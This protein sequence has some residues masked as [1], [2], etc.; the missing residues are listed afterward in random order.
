MVKYSRLL[1]LPV[2]LT[3]FNTDVHAT[4]LKQAS[5]DQKAE[6]IQA[7]MTRDRYLVYSLTA[8]SASFQLSQILPE[9]KKFFGSSSSETTKSPDKKSS[10][11]E[12]FKAGLR[13]MFYTQ[14]G[15]ASTI[16]LGVGIGSSLFISHLYE[17]L[18][19]PDTLRWYIHN[20]APYHAT[21]KMM[22]KKLEQ[23]QDPFIDEEQKETNKKFVILLYDRLV[24]QAQSICAY[25]TYKTGRLDDEEQ[26]LGKRAQRNM[27]AVQNNWLDRISAQL[28][29]NDCDYTT[30]NDLLC[31]YET[32]ISFHVTHFYM[33]EGEMLHDRSVVK[34]QA[35]QSLN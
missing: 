35:K 9:L 30:L 32:D 2:F 22:K 33:V 28:S 29:G 8:L 27:I 18:T 23:L 19:H 6:H 7:K 17:K 11:L 14:E 4:V 3:F 16:Q 20:H 12:G 24:Y 34:K 1:L 15:W 31:A 21:I 10:M 25:M 13:Y 26:M 5:I